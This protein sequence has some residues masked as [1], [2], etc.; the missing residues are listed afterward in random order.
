MEINEKCLKI[1]LKSWDIFWKCLEIFGKSCGIFR[2]CQEILE[3]VWRFPP[4]FMN[5]GF[6]GEG[7]YLEGETSISYGECFIPQGFYSIQKGIYYSKQTTLN[8]NIR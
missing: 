8:I 7:F 1:F 2:K 4:L 6:K 3:N 5:I